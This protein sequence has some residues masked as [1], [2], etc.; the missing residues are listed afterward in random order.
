MVE[1]TLKDAEHK[2]QTTLERARHDFGAIRTGRANPAILESVMVDY[3]G[4][5]TAI[6]HLAAVAVPEPRLMTITPYDR[7]ALAWI[8]KAIQKSDLNLTPT[9]DGQAIRISIPPLTEERRKEMVKL[10]RKKAEEERVAIRNVRRE[11]MEHLKAAEKKSEISEN[12]VKRAEQQ[13]QKITEKYIAEVD[14]AEKSKE[15]EIME[16]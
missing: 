16:V 8:E 15:Q 3:Y 4:T 5:P 14:K 13:I 9:N 7:Q 6:N 2:M 10:L 1:K 11:A 12:E